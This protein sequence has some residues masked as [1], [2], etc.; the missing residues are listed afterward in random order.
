MRRDAPVRVALGYPAPYRVGAS[1]LGFQTVYR[2]LNETDGVCCERF[3]L[4]EGGVVARTVETGMAVGSATAIGFSVSC[5]TELLGLAL[6]LGR[7]GLEP[8]ASRRGEDAPPVIVG[9]PITTL[10][11]RL[12]APFADA[13]VVGDSEEALPALALALGRHPRR[14][15]L[16]AAM[17]GSPPGVWIPSSASAPPPPA[18]APAH[19]LPAYAATWSPEAE[20]RDLFLVEATRGCG[21]ACTFCVLWPSSIAASGSPSPASARIAS[22]RISRATSSAAAPAP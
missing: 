12:V 22:P 9:G 10:D 17:D 8:L 7:A 13:V 2:A 14:T 19:L 18:H 15:E 3:F 16:A 4:E 1:S 11:P 20:L 21:R 5:E 6:L